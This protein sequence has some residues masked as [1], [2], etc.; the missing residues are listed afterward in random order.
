MK[1]NKLIRDK[2]PEYIES[3]GGKAITHIADENEYCEKLKKKL[4]EEVNEYIEDESIEEM[5]DIHEVLKAI[6]DFKKID[7]DQVE[8]IR[9]VKADKKGA[10]K[11]RIILDES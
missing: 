4:L 8:E 1:Y 3:K 7:L 11:H 2:I 10:F 5:A 6:Y 9:K